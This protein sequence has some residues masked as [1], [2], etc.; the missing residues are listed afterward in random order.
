MP[1]HQL[2][3]TWRP[4]RPQYQRGGGSSIEVIVGLK[5]RT[6]RLFT[7]LPLFFNM[8]ASLVSS[9]IFSSADLE[10]ENS[11]QVKVAKAC[12]ETLTKESEMILGCL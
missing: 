7:T 12:V 5:F 2:Y 4:Y 11:E 10:Y 1:T 3:Q 8:S 9:Q 6:D